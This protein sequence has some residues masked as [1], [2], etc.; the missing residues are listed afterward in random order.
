MKT[1]YSYS[2][3]QK[4][5][6][7]PYNYY[8]K[9]IE[10]FDTFPDLKP[11]NAL[12][13][14]T[15]LHH[16]IE[17]GVDSALKVYED[18]YYYPTTGGEDECIKLIETIPK[19][20]QIVKELDAE[21]ITYEYP[22]EYD[23]FIGYIDCLA[24]FK[25]G[26]YGIFDFKYSNA[27]S[28]YKTSA[29]IHVYK[30]FYNV[31]NPNHV[32]SKMGY[33]MV[34][35][36]K[37]KSVWRETVESFRKRLYVDLAKCKVHTHY[38]EY[39]HS[40]VEKFFEQVQDMKDATEYPKNESWKCKWCQFSNYCKRGEVSDMAIPV[41]KKSNPEINKTMRVWLYGANFV[42]KSTLADQFP[43]PIVFST[44]GNGK[45]Y[46]SP[47]VVVADEKNTYGAVS[48]S[49]WKIFKDNL[50]DLA[51]NNSKPE[52]GYETIVID[53]IEG[54]YHHCRNSVLSD[55]NLT[56]ESE[57]PFES[58]RAIRE[59]FFKVYKEIVNLNLN[60]V[61]LSHEVTSRDITK[62]NGDKL[63]VITPKLEEKL[64]SEIA[65]SIDAAMRIINTPEGRFIVFNSDEC[66]FGG[67]RL[68]ISEDKLPLSYDTIKHIYNIKSIANK[69][70]KSTTKEL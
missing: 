45:F 44:D 57:R 51:S 66:V 2:R 36:A 16:G 31:L 11:D 5:V 54:L 21:E 68:Q 46:K 12:L 55:L 1:S 33:I 18:N 30:Y 67:N 41:N 10:K 39:N 47:V 32:V 14:G 37:T 19:V 52:Y 35:K 34:D 17:Y 69:S 22:L 64:L 4:F 25:D 58:W 50:N 43:N 48:R 56:S 59:E 13:L 62:R 65:G 53:L 60:L 49:A 7:C 27:A 28:A 38:I 8:L 40:L 15:A 42:G 6:D 70:I 23:G 24:K 61:L 3:V 29:Q 26:T 63:T 20:Q 9:Y